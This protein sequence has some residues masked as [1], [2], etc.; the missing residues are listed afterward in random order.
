MRLPTH[1]LKKMSKI[2]K[3]TNKTKKL[4]Y[5]LQ[6]ST[7]KY[8]TLNNSSTIKFDNAKPL[9][10]FYLT[11]FC[12]GESSFIISITKRSS[13][14]TSWGI[15]PI[16]KI[17]LHKRDLALLEKIKTFF[18]VGNITISNTRD[19]ATFAVSSVKEINKVIIPHFDKYKLVTN[20]QVD[21]SLFRSVLE[22]IDKGEHLTKE[23]LNKA[24]G[25]RASMN[26]GLIAD[27]FKSDIEPIVRPQN[28]DQVIADPYWLVGFIEAEGC[29]FIDIFKSK[30]HNV[31]HQV[32]LKFQITQHSR[33]YLLMKIL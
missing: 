12:D 7:I 2:Q 23:G 21:Y 17:E 25:F 15:H 19:S 32:K 11:G 20:K 31:G 29:F 4:N 26:S 16:F 5:P 6:L 9:N 28:L 14:K 10:P 18:G 3:I 33:D 22:L 1:C 30:T 13:Y 8:T 24:L 27:E